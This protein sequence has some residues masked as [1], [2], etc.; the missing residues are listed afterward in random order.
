MKKIDK[1][2][3]KKII[4]ICPGG[5]VNPGQSAAIKRW[6]L[7]R[8][9]E[10]TNSISYN[11]IIFGNKKDKEISQKI[12]SESKNNYLYDACA[13]SIQ[14]AK[15]LMEKCDIIISHDSGS[16]HIAS[17]AKTETIALFGPTPSKRFCPKKTTIIETKTLPCYTIYG[18]FRNC[19][20]NQMEEI[21]V[22]QVINS[23]KKLIA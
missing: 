21:L 18:K 3:N 10:L 6:P 19:K 20:E 15:E 8:Y 9:I 5:A 1:K 4:G 23:I 14:E 7:K 12:I 22:E 16:L 17:V 11:F 2:T 13:N